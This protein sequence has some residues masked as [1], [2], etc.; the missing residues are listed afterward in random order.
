LHGHLTLEKLQEREGG[1]F[2]NTK[3]RSKVLIRVVEP[4]DQQIDEKTFLLP[5]K[6]T[7]REKSP[8]PAFVSNLSFKIRV[9][10]EETDTKHDKVITKEEL[11]NLFILAC[12]LGGW[13]KRSRRG[14]GSVVVTEI[15]NEAYNPPVTLQDILT[16]LEHLVPAKFR[17]ADNQIES[18]HVTQNSRDEYPKLWKIEIGSNQRSLIDIGR[19][20]H[21]TKLYDDT[22]INKQDYSKSLGDGTPRYASPVYVSLLSNGLPVVSTLKK[23]SRVSID[24]QNKLKEKIL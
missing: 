6:N 7:D 14:F 3:G 22:S 8:V 5:H 24:L 15:N 23:Q 17:I 2:G 12:T 10:F 21:D 18:T 19:A 16:H 11:K 9:D 13:G 4:I 1:I 20:T